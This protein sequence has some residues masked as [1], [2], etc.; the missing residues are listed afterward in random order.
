MPPWQELLLKGA[1]MSVADMR[2]MA[3]WGGR[4]LSPAVA[5][6]IAAAAVASKLAELKAL[7]K[8]K[9][10][11]RLVWLLTKNPMIAVGSPQPDATE[12]AAV[13]M[14]FLS[15]FQT[16][17]IVGLR[18]SVSAPC[19]PVEGC[20][21]LFACT[22][23]CYSSMIPFVGFLLEQDADVC[24]MRWRACQACSASPL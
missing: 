12:H 21:S 11:V 23:C 4:T 7:R 18:S 20:R 10:E 6:G 9:V 15:A 14:R 1:G 22:G 16:G 13:S 8:V 2:R 17:G 3:R 24:R 5:Q 19:A